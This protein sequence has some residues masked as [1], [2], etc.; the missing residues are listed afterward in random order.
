MMVRS[1]R[2]TARWRGIDLW[3]LLTLFVLGLGVRWLYARA[4]VFPPLDDPAFY[5]TTAENV[6]TGRGLVVDVLWSYQVPFPS[7]TH[8]SHEHWMPLTTGLI[9]AAFSIQKAV[10]GI[11]EPSLRTG[12]MPGLVLGALLAPLTYLLGRRVLPQGPSSRWISLG[13]ALLVAANP[14]LAYQSASIDSSA[15]FTFLVACALALSVRKPGEQGGYLGAGLLIGLSYLTRSDGL[16]L[17]FAIPLAWWLLPMPSRLSVEIPD[18]PAARL[19]WEQWPRQKP[20]KEDRLRATGPGLRHVIDLCVAF[21]L[22]AAPWLVRNHLAFGT[23]LPSSILSQA[24]LTDYVDTFN[25]LARPTPD[26]WL[27]QPWS[28]LL[29]QRLQAL[30]HN[31]KALLAGTFPWGVFALL[32]LW[33]LRR[34]SLV[35]SAFVYGMFMFLGLAL[36]FPISTM[37]GTFYHSFGTVLP[38]LALTA[39]YAVWQVARLLRRRGKLPEFLATSITIAFLVL[40]GWQVM[41]TLSAVAE[42]HK[43][44]K[45]QFEAAA[46]WLAQNANSGD[47]IMTTQPYSLN[48]ASGHPCIVLPGNDPPDSARQAAER[49]GARYLIVTEQFGL[50]PDI[51]AAQP[52]PRFRLLAEIQGS[53]IYQIGGGQP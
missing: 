12:Q 32:G 20:S 48:Y 16:L 50:Y 23:P 1:R 27:A 6:V 7:V 15:P 34:N 18:T 2:N 26:T 4:V 38:F 24:W 25:Y 17:L 40:C 13:A 47:V 19:A 53:Q 28:A 30:A 33:L 31:G 5:L 29:D 51:L 3:L 42:R 36:V 43:A 39:M 46:D 10:T 9:A 44:E 8:P 52:D 37:H 14:V 41:Q 22:I 35:F 11:L 21:A 45:E 49:Y